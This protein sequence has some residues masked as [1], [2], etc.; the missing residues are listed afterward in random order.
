MKLFALGTDDTRRE[1]K[2]EEF[3]PHKNFLILKFVGIDSISDADP[4]VKSELQVPR[5]E[6]AQLEAGWMYVSDLL[7]C[8]VYDS[9]RE[10]GQV[11]DVQFGA[12]EAPLLQVQSGARRHEIPFAE[13]FLR[14]VDLRGKRIDMQLPEGLLDL[15][16]P[17]TAE[18]KEQQRKKS[19]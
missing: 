13:A 12:G 6:R 18:E 8:D 17:L 14:Q 2:V 1:V 9:G 7:G 3:W 4:L 10:V 19:M 11:L 15:D 5:S 16:A